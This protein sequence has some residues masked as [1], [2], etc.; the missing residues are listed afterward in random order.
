MLEKQRGFAGKGGIIRE[1]DLQVLFTGPKE[2]CELKSSAVT[3]DGDLA[4]DLFDISPLP[5][6]GNQGDDDA[7]TSSA[8]AG[9]SPTEREIVMRLIRTEED[10]AL[11][12]NMIIQMN[13][14]LASHTQRLEGIEQVGKELL[15]RNPTKQT[16][17]NIVYAYVSARAVAE[18]REL[19]GQNRNHFALALEKMVYRDDPKEM[20]LLV[21]DRNE[22]ERV[23][24]IQ[25][26][27]NKYYEVPE[28]L[29]DDVWRKIKETLNSR[30]RRLRKAI[31][32]RQ[33][34]SEGSRLQE[35]DTLYR[36]DLYD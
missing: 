5:Q 13:A 33:S 1:S 3:T 7:P 6:D 35:E 11:M 12:K 34:T 9:P 31:R 2:V 25:Q 19:K 8:D 24:F 15:R 10:T 22:A 18:L 14:I 30:V 23:L 29:R 21:D 26:C 28:H 4:D 36:L 27:V 17:G 16:Q 20:E 32:D